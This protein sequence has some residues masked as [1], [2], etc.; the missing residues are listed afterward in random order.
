MIE[1]VA[2]VSLLEVVFLEVRMK[3]EK[4]WKGGGKK[5]SNIEGIIF[6][7]ESVPLCRGFSSVGD[8]YFRNQD[9]LKEVWGGFD[10][11]VT[12]V[13]FQCESIESV[14]CGENLE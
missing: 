2:D 4:G 3:S 1:L 11:L 13:G 10:D 6:A 5:C 7:A 12:D 9:A 8:F 14:E